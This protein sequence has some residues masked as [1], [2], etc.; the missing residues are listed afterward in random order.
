MW[1]FITPSSIG[2]K[3]QRLWNFSG[4]ELSVII[5]LH[6]DIVFVA[7]H[8]TLSRRSLCFFCTG[9]PRSGY[10]TPCEAW[11]GQSGGGGVSPLLTCWPSFSCTPG[12]NWPS[13]PPVHTAD[14]S[15]VRWDYKKREVLHYCPQ[16][17][18]RKKKDQLKIASSSA[19][20]GRH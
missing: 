17:P 14:S 5:W 19:V 12:S 16:R 9:K 6:V 8:Q 15:N 20:W 2:I 11:P 13:W 1:K 10:S 18:K 3:E 4:N 7:L